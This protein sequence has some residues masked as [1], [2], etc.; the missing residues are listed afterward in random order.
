MDESQG[1]RFHSLS[2]LFGRTEVRSVIP[3]ARGLIRVAALT[4]TSLIQ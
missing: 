2:S 3:L 4:L 1:E